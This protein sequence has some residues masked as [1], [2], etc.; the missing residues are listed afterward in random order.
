MTTARRSGLWVE[1]GDACYHRRSKRTTYM[2]I[3]EVITT[4]MV[5]TETT[6]SVP[7]LA[8]ERKTKESSL[9]C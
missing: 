1:V 2:V 6:S 7:L 9:S 3:M 5:Y 4:A 8:V